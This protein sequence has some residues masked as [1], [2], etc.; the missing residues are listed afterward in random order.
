MDVE[1]MSVCAFT[2]VTMPAVAAVVLPLMTAA[3]DDEAVL[4]LLLMAVCAFVMA[5]PREEDA[6]VTSDCKAREPAERLAP[7]RVLEA[8]DQ[9]E[10]MVPFRVETTWRPMVP[11]P[12][13]VEVATFQMEA[14]R[15][16][17]DDAS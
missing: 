2:L 13:S 1:A 12:L 14:G 11:A 6:V 3:K 7:V 10:A 5:E 17:M 4:V 9:M 15:F 8:C 16:V